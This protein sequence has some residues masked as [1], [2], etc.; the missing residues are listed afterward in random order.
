MCNQHLKFGRLIDRAEQLG[1]QWVATGHFARVEPD[2]SGSRILLKRGA[3]PLKDQSYFLFSLGQ[4]QL[5]RMLF[6]LGGMTK[7]QTRAAARDSGLKTADKAESMEI[8]FVPDND[9]G[10]FLEQ[11]DLVRKHAGEIVD[12]EGRVLGRHEGIEFY[13]V[14][15]RKGLGI[16]S[17]RPLY[18]VELD[19]LRNRVVVGEEAALARAEFEVQRCN[20]IAFE[21]LREPA[22]AFGPNPLPAPRCARD[23]H[24]ARRRQG[25]G[26]VEFAAASG[27]SRPGGGILSR[28]PGARRRVDLLGLRGPGGRPEKKARRA[29]F[30]LEQSSWPADNECVKILWARRPGV[31]LGSLEV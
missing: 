25:P 26:E 4:D 24:P 12:L 23:D 9:Y 18:V 15:Q 22:E 16:S 21:D 8:C 1:A 11:A 5:R 10:R 27:Y 17:V 31:D 30:S 29:E 20:W 13:T 19:A 2:S 3:D 7:P 14:G 28:G 6:P